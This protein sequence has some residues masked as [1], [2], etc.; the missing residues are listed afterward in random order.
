M[1]TFWKNLWQLIEPSHKRI[2]ILVIFLI[3]EEVVNLAAPYVLKLIIDTLTN[4]DYSK[5]VLLLWLALSMLVAEEFRALVGWFNNKNINKTI[6]DIEYYLPGRAHQQLMLLSLGYHERENTG[7]KITKV[8]RGID[9]ISQLLTNVLWEV[10]PTC[11]QLIV[12]FIILC[13][14]DW[15]FA[16]AFL[17]FTPQFIW[18]TQKVNR[19]LHPVRQEIHQTWEAAA[20]KMGQA[21]I[22]INTVQSFVQEKRETGEYRDIREII[23]RKEQGAWEKIFDYTFFR[24]TVINIGRVAMLI[25]GV[26]LVFR[27]AVT[28]GTLVFVITIAEKAFFALFRLSRFYDRIQDSAEAV[29]RFISLANEKTEIKNPEHGLKPKI[30]RGDIEFKNVFFTYGESK[31]TALQGVSFKITAGTTNAFVGPSGGGKTT[32]ARLIY[33][34]YDPQ[35]GSVVLDGHDLREYDLHYF[36]EHIAIVPQE[37]EIFNASIRDNIAYA[38][39]RSSFNEVKKAAR[40][41]NAEE[42]ILNFKDG[43]DTE[44]GE[45]GI[46]LSGGQRQRIGIARAILA[47]P[48]ILIFDEATSSLDSQSEKFIQEAMKRVSEKRTVIIIAHRL[49]TIRHAGQIFVLDNGKLVEQG[50]HQELSNVKGGLYAKLLKLQGS[51]D[52]D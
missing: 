33:R 35:K 47:N 23:R 45:R 43:Y 36:R 17:F 25:L 30:I 21:I 26:R 28:I 13:Y 38:N 34:H 5:I 2:K 37:V 10:G 39:P 32:V 4:F 42:F 41:A 46:R 6:L 7:N 3:F 16:A 8:Q 40:I 27:G 11:F 29:D 51:G 15:R 48:K 24:D 52:V 50:S 44:V 22:N 18:L 20:G 12:T 14:I 1:L 31:A 49:S 9:H 19:E